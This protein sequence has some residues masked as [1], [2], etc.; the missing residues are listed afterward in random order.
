MTFTLVEVLIGVMA[1][2]MMIGLTVFIRLA[3]QVVRMAYQ[4][5]QVS[6]AVAE[7]TPSVQRV[8]DQGA[9]EIEK[10]RTITATAGQIVSEIHSV[11]EAASEV[12]TQFARGF[13][14]QVTRY[15]ALLAGARAGFEVLRHARG[16][17]GGVGAENENSDPEIGDFDRLRQ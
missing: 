11:T 13:G 3:G 17:G 15:R 6:R 12:T 16:N 9:V 7:L 14:G 5:E 1:L 10:M 4:V 8:V 2:A